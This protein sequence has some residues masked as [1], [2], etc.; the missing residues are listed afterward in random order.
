M[1]LK[2]ERFYGKGEGALAACLAIYNE[3]IEKTTITF[4]EEPLSRD[5]F[6]ARVAKITK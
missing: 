6:A 5:A 1:Q 3:Y 4:E 2:L